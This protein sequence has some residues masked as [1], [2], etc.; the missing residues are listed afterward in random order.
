MTN[1][2]TIAKVR[3]AMLCMQR[4]SWEQG[5][6]AQALL[7]LK[8]DKMVVLF[9]HDALVRQLED[10]RMAAIGGDG[11]IV[12]A[13]A[14]GEAA[15]V[16]AMLTGEKRYSVAADRMVEWL[17]KPE[18]RNPDGIIYH[19][20]DSRQV[21]V[22]S[23]YMAPP[24]LAAAGHYTEA[25]AQ[26]DGFRRL[27][28]NGDT[29]LFS[30]IWDDS[31]QVFERKAFWGV[32][33]GWAVTGMIRV[34]AFLPDQFKLQRTRILGYARETIGECL[35][36]QRSDG[37][38]HDVL[39]DPQS[40]VETN[41]AQMF[42][43]GIFRLAALGEIDSSWLD[44]AQRMREAARAK[45]DSWGLVQGVCGAPRFDGPGTAPEGQAFFLLMEAAARQFE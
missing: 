29:K 21:W 14:N 11:S 3:D 37:L 17:L 8:D 1:A 35:K 6:C 16:A 41:S 5:V 28:W 23:F 33:N 40:F 34:A 9:A 12:D 36:Y 13:A 31:R 43:Y 44:L 30:H 38:F 15:L 4:H 22:D 18:N 26:I 27:L 19:R 10:G 45:V 42:A 25:I 2:E 20:T 7:E 24:F 32:G 39:D